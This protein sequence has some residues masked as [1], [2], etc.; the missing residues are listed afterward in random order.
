MNNE[1]VKVPV[2]ELLKLEES[3]EKLYDFL[4]GKLSEQDLLQ[5]VNVTGQIWKVANR[6][7]WSL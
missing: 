6:K 7:D 2:E 3:R 5:L 1:Y 4:E